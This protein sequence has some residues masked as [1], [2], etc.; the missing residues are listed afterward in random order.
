MRRVAVSL[1]LLTL[2]VALLLLLAD[3]APGRRRNTA[4]ESGAR[5]ADGVEQSN[6]PTQP[7]V[8]TAATA[9][10]S[11]RPRVKILG[12]ARTWDEDTH[13][14]R[15]LPGAR[16]QVFRMPAG[17]ADGDDLLLLNPGKLHASV[18]A[19]AKG[20]FDFDLDPE[21][22]WVIRADAQGFAPAWEGIQGPGEHDLEMI[23]VPAPAR[24][25]RVVD[26]D[27]RPV[28]GAEVIVYRDYALPMSRHLS[29]ADGS[30]T[31]PL[32]DEEASLVVR[33]QGY[34]TRHIEDDLGELLEEQQGRIVLKP[35]FTLRG[36]VTDEAG[37]PLAGVRASLRD[38]LPRHRTTTEDGRFSFE[39][40]EL[41]EYNVNLTLE[42]YGFW[43]VSVWPDDS[44]HT[45]A[46]FSLV[47]LR[48]V[49]LF[50]DGTPA[51]GVNVRAGH[52]V[53]RSDEN[54]RFHIARVSPRG[55]VLIAWRDKY[56]VQGDKSRVLYRYTGRGHFKV[57]PGRKPEDVTIQLKEQGL[58]YMRARVFDVSGA[59]LA[60]MPVNVTSTQGMGYSSTRT[61]AE[62]RV[63]VACPVFPGAEVIVN[64]PWNKKERRTALHA[65]VR[66]ATHREDEVALHM[67]PPITFTIIA[68]GAGMASLPAG[69]QAHI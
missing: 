58:S 21:P 9:A 66:T 60:K 36:L 28:A 3:E 4:R 68:R 30:L 17:W 63:T 13:D 41:K 31:L 12:S 43:S 20:A 48:G 25:V 52:A 55:V 34:A 37:V 61:D 22:E 69:T 32:P 54:G 8:A 16:V 64:V 42:G 49:V 33:A 47:P 23:L 18:T 59:P 56:P 26:H 39:A 46:M 7:G 38:D 62:G 2:A 45:F 24:P 57:E 50:P 5:G 6:A 35:A 51:A 53:T 1:L 27:D 67:S 14:E 65:R 15:V 40:L 19:D 10:T 44:E 11:K 29:A